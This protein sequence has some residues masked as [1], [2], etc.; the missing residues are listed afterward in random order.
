MPASRWR[1]RQ[2]AFREREVADILELDSRVR[3]V[4]SKGYRRNQLQIWNHDG[5]SLMHALI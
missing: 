2:H 3:V 4:A 5:T 1:F